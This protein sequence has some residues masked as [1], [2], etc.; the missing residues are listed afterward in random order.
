MIARS[1][2][3]YVPTRQHANGPLLTEVVAAIQ[4]KLEKSLANKEGTLCFDGWKDI[5]KR[6]LVGFVINFDFEVSRFSDGGVRGMRERR[7]TPSWLVQTHLTNWHDITDAPVK[8]HKLFI[9]LIM[10][11]MDWLSARNCEFC[12]SLFF[13]NSGLSN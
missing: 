3:P 7:L 2:T 5:V 9:D 13:L 12:L 1:Q 8:D 10:K 11:E 4:A 6:A